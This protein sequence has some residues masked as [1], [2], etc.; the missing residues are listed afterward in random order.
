MPDAKAVTVAKETLGAL[1]AACGVA[2]TD[3]LAELSPTEFR[4]FTHKVYVVP[5]LKPR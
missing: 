5:L 4:A 3:P 1:T 2:N